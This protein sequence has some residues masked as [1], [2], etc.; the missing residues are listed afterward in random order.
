MVQ[1]SGVVVRDQPLIG[2]PSIYGHSNASSLRTRR[3]Q[4]GID[5]GKRCEVVGS[6]MSNCEGVMEKK[7]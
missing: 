4:G 6:Q 3:E 1:A 5:T 2:E 7:S